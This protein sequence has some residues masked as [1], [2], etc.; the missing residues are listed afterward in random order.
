MSQ[1]E[2]LEAKG[3]IAHSYDALFSI[4]KRI[5]KINDLAIPV[6]R[7]LGTDQIGV[8]VLLFVVCVILYGLV[9]APAMTLLGIQKTPWFLFLWLIG[10]PAL[11]AQQITKPLKYGKSIAGTINS[12]MRFYLDD[13][14]HRRGLPVPPHDAPVNIPVAHYERSWVAGEDLAAVKPGEVDWTDHITENRMAGAPVNLETWM[15]TRQAE[16]RAAEIVAATARRA[17]VDRTVHYRRGSSATVLLPE[18][19]GAPQ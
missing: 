4:R 9:L 3:L 5:R 6:R 17:T 15:D 12:K 1:A 2:D 13:R 8:F 19:Q 16:N 10:P 18:Q 14:I 7:G 11:A